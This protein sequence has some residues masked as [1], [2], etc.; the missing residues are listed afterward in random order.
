VIH[1]QTLTFSMLT[2]TLFKYVGYY[3]HLS[4]HAQSSLKVGKP[5]D[6]VVNGR[7]P[8]PKNP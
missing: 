7:N 1:K 4:F 5:L 2:A 3:F 8:F 6:L